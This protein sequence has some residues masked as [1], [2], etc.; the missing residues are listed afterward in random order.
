MYA[1][2]AELG[3]LKGFFFETLLKTFL[4]VAFLL[5]KVSSTFAIGRMAGVRGCVG[6]LL[7]PMIFH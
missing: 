7:V 2:R 5:Q 4:L 1:S 3:V 6:L